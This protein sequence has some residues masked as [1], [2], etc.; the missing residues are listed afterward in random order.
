M[1]H[2]VL[3]PDAHSLLCANTRL[4][5]GTA[6]NFRQ[7]TSFFN[8]ENVSSTMNHSMADTIHLTKV[9]D[10]PGIYQ[11][12]DTMPL[13]CNVSLH[14]RVQAGCFEIH[15][16]PALAQPACSAS[17]SQELEP[18]LS[19]R[20][21]P[22]QV[23]RFR[24]SQVGIHVSCFFYSSSHRM[25]ELQLEKRACS[26]LLPRLELSIGAV[27]INALADHSPFSPYRTTVTAAGTPAYMAPELLQNRPF[28][29]SVDV[30]AFGV[31]LCE[32]IW[33]ILFTWYW[34]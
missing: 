22:R 33:I 18:S 24:P 11:Y 15:G 17:R 13:T 9:A 20:G 32:V 30:Y 23:V 27:T 6:L 14:C 4:P 2:Y 10:I 21:W 1:H 16:V 19:R 26:V 29:K 7:D 28:N 34:L 31:L 5:S 8:V 12:I 25:P 3:Y